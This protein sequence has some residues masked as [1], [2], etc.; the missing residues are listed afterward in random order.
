[1]P[2]LRL[3]FVPDGA[4]VVFDRPV[5]VRRVE[6]HAGEG[7][8]GGTRRL[9]LVERPGGKPITRYRLFFQPQETS[10]AVKVFLRDETPLETEGRPGAGVFSSVSMALE[11]P[12]TGEAD[13]TERW[14]QSPMRKDAYV[15]PGA[16][17]TAEVELLAWSKPVDGVLSVVLEPG[18]EFAGKEFEGV[19]KSEEGGPSLVVSHGVSIDAPMQVVQFLIPLK[20]TAKEGKRSS[21]SLWFTSRTGGEFPPLK[22][23]VAI[24]VIRPGELAARVQPPVVRMPT[25]AQGEPDVRKE[26]DTILLP[27]PTWLAVRRALGVSEAYSD[28]YAPAAYE[29]AS[30]LNQSA[31]ATAIAVSMRV[32]RADDNEPAPGFRPPDYLGGGS[33]GLT[34]TAELKPGVENP[35]ALPIY[36]RSGEVLPGRYRSIIEAR[37]LGTDVVASRVEHPFQVRAVDLRALVVTVAAV[38]LS[39]AGL[40][41]FLAKQRRIFGSFRVSE[42]VLIALFATM[43][44]VLVIFPGSILGPVASA[45]AGPFG[46]LIQGIFFEALRVLVTVTLLVLVPRVGTVTLVSIVRYLIGG[47]AFGGFTP[48]DLFYI[49]SSVAVME[50]GLYVAG[51]TSG[52]SG[53]GVLRRE[54]LN[55]AAFLRVALVMG[56]ANAVTQHVIYCLNISFYRLYFADWFI[57]LGVLV[58]GFLY[59]AL[60]TFPGLRLGLRLRRI[61]E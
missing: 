48:V 36:V 35:V 13:I 37:I 21:V 3:E 18:M 42:L 39:V 26:R 57:V 55:W 25:D 40:V 38:L 31:D 5:A 1:M 60:G 9:L 2:A 59:A 8:G 49:G 4:V 7:G 22:R 34:V 50:T 30:Y 14:G 20:V 15:T 47:L 33:G 61:S 54:S 41:V 52:A 53:R 23:S 17:L 44:F 56:L 43:T 27:N 45:L 11:V 24:R 58:N 32:T 19:F 29:T 51:V 46:F 6:L 28:Y 16:A 12:Y 10:Y